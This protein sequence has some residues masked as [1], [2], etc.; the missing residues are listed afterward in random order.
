[1][2]TERRQREGKGGKGPS[3]LRISLRAQC[4]EHE[5]HGFSLDISGAFRTPGSRPSIYRSSLACKLTGKLTGA[6]AALSSRRLEVMMQLR[7]E[8]A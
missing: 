1:M 2:H 7:N 3:L 8:L 5:M 4:D 6:R